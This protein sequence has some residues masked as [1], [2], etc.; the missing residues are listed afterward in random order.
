MALRYP[1]PIPSLSDRDIER[2]WSHVDVRGPDECW[3]W[4]AS[5][6]KTGYGQFML[7]KPNNRCWLASRIAFRV[8]HGEDAYP[9]SVLHSCDFPACCNG[10]HLFKGDQLDNMR[11]ASRKGRINQGSNN[12]WAKL[13]DEKVRQIR[14][15]HASGS[16]DMEHIA[17]RFRV[18]PSLIS[19][20][21][22][23]RIWRHI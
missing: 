3:P 12:Y 14:N 4:K 5:R 19:M 23:R 10:K 22:S 16:L 11:D 1:I 9:L 21:I 18:T 2:F 17:K 13:S 20:I 7:G 8:T 6:N 15:I